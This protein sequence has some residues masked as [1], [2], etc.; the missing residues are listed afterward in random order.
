MPG[1]RVEELDEYTGVEG[2]IRY[3]VRCRVAGGHPIFRTR[4]GG[5]EFGDWVLAVCFGAADKVPT[6]DIE[7]VPR[8]LVKELERYSGDWRFLRKRYR[9][10]YEEEARREL[11]RLGLSKDEIEDIV[12][13]GLI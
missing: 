10:I 11:A 9:D 6:I 7:G 5:A 8:D 3:A 1:D 12:K 13:R 2:L 4:F